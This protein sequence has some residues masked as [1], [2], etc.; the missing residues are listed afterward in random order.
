MQPAISNDPDWIR[1]AVLAYFFPERGSFFAARA[2]A[3]RSRLLA[4]WTFF[5]SFVADE[6]EPDGQIGLTSSI[7]HVGPPGKSGDSA[8]TNAGASPPRIQTCE[9]GGVLPSSEAIAPVT[10][11]TCTFTT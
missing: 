11:G 4:G 2:D 10:P 9:S 5:E 3:G 8:F 1:E 7:R 6:I